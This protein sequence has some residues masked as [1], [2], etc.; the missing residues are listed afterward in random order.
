[1]ESLVLTASRA[2]AEVR[3]GHALS[4]FEESLSNERKAL[5][6]SYRA[7]AVSSTPTLEDVRRVVAE[8]DHQSG[9][10]PVGGRFVKILKVVQQ[11]AVFGDVIVGG[12]G[13]I[14]PSAIWGCVRLTLTVR[15][16]RNVE[17][18]VTV[19]SV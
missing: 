19:E 14:V 12:A 9:G 6:Q 11:F 8:F 7:Q 13:N 3:L 16:G 10:K 15:L 18:L 17:L 2:K 4:V 1:M 5:F